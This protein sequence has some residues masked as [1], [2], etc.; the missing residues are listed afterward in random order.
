MYTRCTCIYTRIYTP[1]IHLT[2]LQYHIYTLYTPRIRSSYTLY[3]LFGDPYTSN[4]IQGSAFEGQTAMPWSFAVLNLA[5]QKMLNDQSGLLDN[6]GGAKVRAAVSNM[7]FVVRRSAPCFAMMQRLLKTPNAG[8][9]FWLLRRLKKVR[10]RSVGHDV[11]LIGFQS[12]F[13]S[14][15]H[16]RMYTLSYFS[17]VHY[18]QL[19]VF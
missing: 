19:V 8:Q 1:Y 12:A 13:N 6:L 7:L 14:F 17:Q 3:T 16:G 5:L 4:Y 11:V 2:H 18:Y 10:L 9:L 15:G